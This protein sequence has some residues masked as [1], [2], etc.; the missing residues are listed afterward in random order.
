LFLRFG[1]Y[2][3]L[4]RADVEHTLVPAHQFELQPTTGQR[5]FKFGDQTGR[6]WPVVSASAVFDLDLH[7]LSVTGASAGC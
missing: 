6:L 2:Q 5:S 3:P 1:E 7:G 4:L